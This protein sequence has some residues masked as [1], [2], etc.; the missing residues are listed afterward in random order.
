[1]LSKYYL[2]I[3][4]KYGIKIDEVNKSVSN[5]D[6]KSKYVAHYRNL[7]LY[8]SLGMKLTEVHRSLKFKQSGWLK[9]Y[10]DF[11][12]DKRKN[13][14]NSFEKNY[15]K[16]MNNS[17]FGKT[18]ENLRKRI[19][20]TLVDN[21]KEYITCESR[22]SFISQKI[23][24][25][26]F[27]AIHEIK[28]ILTLN[29][30]IYVGFSILDLSKLLMYEIHYKYIK[31]KSDA[32]LLLTDTDSLVYEIKTENGYDDFYQD[33][34]LFDPSDYSLDLKF[35]DPTNKKVIGKME[36]EFKGKII[37]EFAR[38]KSKKFSLISVDDEEVTKAKG[39]NKKTKHKEFVDVLCNKKVI[40]HNMKRI[41][42][43]LNRIGTYDVRKIS[44]SCFDDKRYVLDDGVNTL[45]FWHIW[46][47]DKIDNSDKDFIGLIKS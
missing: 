41:Q 19:S 38:L 21:A 24:S 9:K 23:S 5:L 11:N 36:D 7:Q 15:F 16:L 43:K 37:D 39:V 13:T 32:K 14:A 2:N 3:A 17:V 34:N 40:R 47:F 45:A 44:L 22:P 8:L 10:V 12:T 18:M 20:V 27:V 6:N 46:L 33:K 1:M 29:K 4:N 31:S 28:P 42:S 30:P 25:R 35:F 26:N